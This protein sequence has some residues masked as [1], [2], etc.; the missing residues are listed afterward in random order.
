MST[1]CHAFAR[2]PDTGDPQWVGKVKM[3]PRGNVMA[4]PSSTSGDHTSYPPDGRIHETRPH[5]PSSEYHTYR[6]PGPPLSDVTFRTFEHFRVSS[7]GP[8]PEAEPG[9]AVPENSL[10]VDCPSSGTGAFFVAVVGDAYADQA[11]HD[12]GELTSGSTYRIGSAQGQTFF[13][14][15]D[16]EGTVLPST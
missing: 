7:T 10:V 4:I 11:E 3:S 12:L 13:L 9:K 1:E 5:G 8:P 15:W 16:S 2:D 6:E 14:G